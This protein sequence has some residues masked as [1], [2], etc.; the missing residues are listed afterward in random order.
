MT[1]A[2]IVGGGIAG[3]ATAIAL[4]TVGLSSVICEAY[5][6]GGED[7]GAFLTVMHNGMAARQQHKPPSVRGLAIRRR[8]VDQRN[9]RQLRTWSGRCTGGYP[10][11]ERRREQP[12]QSA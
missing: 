5:P 10:P 7:T 11:D 9:G 4:R 1:T 2:L 3:T 8:Q 6:S 12:N